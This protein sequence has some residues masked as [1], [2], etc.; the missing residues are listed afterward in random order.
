[1]RLKQL[2]ALRG[3]IIILM[4]LDHANSLV[5]RAKLSSELWASL[6]PEYG[7]SA[8]AFLTRFVTH[9]AAPGFFFLMGAG[10]TLFM[11]SRLKKGWSRGRILRYFAL[12]G[13]LLVVLQFLVENPAWRMGRVGLPENYIYVG[14][15][16]ALGSGMM[17][18]SLLT[19]L[20]QPMLIGLSGV[21]IVM[22]EFTLPAAADAVSGMPFLQTLLMVPGYGPLWGDSGFWVLYPI[23]PWLGVVGMGIAFGRWLDAK[24][25]QALRSTTW[26]GL[27]ALVVFVILRW[28]G[29]YGNIRPAAGEDWIAFFNLVKYPPALVFLCLTMGINFL[30][31]RLFT[32]LEAVLPSL[33]QPLSVFGRAPLFFYLTHLYLYGLVGS[34]IAPDGM[35]IVQ[36]L[37]LWLLGLAAL[38]PLCQWYSRFKST[39]PLESVWRL[40]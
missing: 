6:F 33:L 17:L 24:P 16:F 28:I 31:I 39:R 12:R 30:L 38:Y 32:W 7:G 3:T 13:F 14:V 18:G 10:M 37:P 15:L 19:L 34:W 36:M 11:A 22:T 5:A 26:L 9:L 27:G 40:F 8:L 4:A 1:M 2:D 25:E 23:L 29:G 21:L 35:P 20:S